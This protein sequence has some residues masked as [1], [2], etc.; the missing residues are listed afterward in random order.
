[1]PPDRARSADRR[2]TAARRPGAAP[3]APHR[4]YAP[5]VEAAS[6]A[7]AA[8]SNALLR[9]HPASLARIGIDTGE[10]PSAAR[11]R[12]RRTGT[13][14]AVGHHPPPGLADLEP[15]PLPCRHRRSLQTPSATALEIG[16]GIGSAARAKVGWTAVSSRSAPDG[17][18]PCA[19]STSPVQWA[20]RTAHR[21]ATGS[22]HIPT[23][24][25]RAAKSAVPGF[26]QAGVEDR[27]VR[28]VSTRT[29]TGGTAFQASRK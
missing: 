20:R 16:H 4:A 9:R 14:P 3:S 10:P 24:A 6:N 26:A 27:R 22:A 11:A 8:S 7:P 5:A 12:H 17:H 18:S 25:A 28:R 2:A 21:T 19:A 1:M 29:R 23:T 15:H 13:M